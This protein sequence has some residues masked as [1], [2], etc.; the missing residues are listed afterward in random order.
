LQTRTASTRSSAVA[1]NEA[2]MLMMA[3]QPFLIFGTNCCQTFGSLVGRPSF[4]SRAC[5]WI[6]AAPALAASIDCAA[7]SSGLQGR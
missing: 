4:R 5:R 7:M 6:I 1:P 3:S 2:D